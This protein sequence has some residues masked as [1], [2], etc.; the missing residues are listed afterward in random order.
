MLTSKLTFQ[1]LF[2]AIQFI[3][4]ILLD[5]SKV[6]QYLHELSEINTIVCALSEKRMYNSVAQRIYGQ[7]RYA[8]EIITR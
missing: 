3:D 5:W 4:I 1:F 2:T 7:L 6:S 8:Q